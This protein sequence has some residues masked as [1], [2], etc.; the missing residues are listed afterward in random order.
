M[1]AMLPLFATAAASDPASHK[2]ANVLAAARA[3]TPQLNRSRALDRRLVANTMTMAFGGSDAEGAWIWRDAYDAVEAALVLQLR[4]LSPQISR[5]EDAPAEICAHHDV[6]PLVGA[7][8]LDDAVVAL[9]QFHEIVGLQDHVV[10]F[11]EREW[12]V[13][14]EA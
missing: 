14:L 10:E 5:L 4:R 6:A 1:N 7:A 12:L 9:V 13:A 8:H 11:E 3:L 2:A